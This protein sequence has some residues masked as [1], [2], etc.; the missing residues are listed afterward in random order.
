MR[1][2]RSTPYLWQT[3]MKLF[4]FLKGQI[5]QDQPVDSDFPAGA[6]KLIRAVGKDHIGV[7]HK[8]HRDRC[9]IPAE[10]PDKLQKSCPW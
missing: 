1:E 2:I 10:F 3:G 8:Y 6:D 9:H 7:G 5:G 4:F